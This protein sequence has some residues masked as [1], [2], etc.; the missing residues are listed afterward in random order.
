MHKTHISML[1]S[2]ALVSADRDAW[3]SDWALSSIWG[4]DPDIPQERIDYLGRIYDCAHM[5]VK[6]ICR[7]SGLTQAALSGRFCIPKR[8]VE[9]W[10]R[11]LRTPP[12]YVRLLIAL[13]LGLI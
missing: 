10:C 13:A 9:D 1:W 7:S 6:S 5:D 2:D 8:T 3:I 4:D 12:D 11:G